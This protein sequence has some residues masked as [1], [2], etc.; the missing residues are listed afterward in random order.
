MRQA[1]PIFERARD[2]FRGLSAFEFFSEAGLARVLAHHPL[3]RPFAS[4][5]PAYVLVE[6]ER[7]SETPP[8]DLEEF[9]A[10]LIECGLAADALLS[11][12][13][14]QAD[15][16]M[17][18]R[19]RIGETLSTHY[20]PHKNDLAVPIPA[21]PQFVEELTALLTAEY[22]GMEAVIFGHLGDGNLHVN[23][24]KPEGLGPE[25]FLAACHAADHKIFGLV[26]KFGGSISAEHGIGLLKKEFLHY[27]RSPAEIAIMRGI[28]AVFDPN[29]ILNPGKIFDAALPA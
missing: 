8:D 28:K 2:R 20:F 5:Y 18:M 27:C 19:E 25:Q 10:G 29:G 15:E 9:F 23:V 24:L 1:L 6:I 3:P 4:I 14:R 21:V 7:D 16:F 12:S 17:A 22:P 11:Q 26:A 13:Q